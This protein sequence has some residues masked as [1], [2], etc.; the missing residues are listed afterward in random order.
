MDMCAWIDPR[1]IHFTHARISPH[2]SGCGRSVIDTLEEL[3]MGYI[4]PA[5]LPRIKVVPLV[6]Q[7][8]AEFLQQRKVN[9]R[10][11]AAAAANALTYY[12]SL[13]NRRLWVLKQCRE[14]GLLHENDHK[15]LVV[16]DLRKQMREKY[17]IDRCSLSA[18]FMTVKSATGTKTEDG[19]THK[20][21]GEDHRGPDDLPQSSS[22][23]IPLEGVGRA[24]GPSLCKGSSDVA[25]L[26]YAI[27][28]GVGLVSAMEERQIE[29]ANCATEGLLTQGTPALK[30]TW[31]G[32]SD[33]N[34]CSFSANG[35]SLLVGMSDGT[36][37]L[38]D[39]T[40]ATLIH[41]E[42]TVAEVTMCSFAPDGR[43]FFGASP[44]GAIQTWSSEGIQW[45][46][47]IGGG[48]GNSTQLHSCCYSP[49]GNVILGASSDGRLTF[50]RKHTAPIQEDDC[51]KRNKCLWQKEDTFDG[52]G[53]AAAYTCAFS[54]DG[55][56]VLS[57]S[58]DNTLRL[59]CIESKG[60]LKTLDGGHSGEI[61]CCEFSPCGTKILSGSED[62]T[63]VLWDIAS[64]KAE[65]TMNGHCE[66]VLTCCFSPDGKLIASGSVDNTLKLWD[67]SSGKL[68]ASLQHFSWVKTCKFSPDGKAVVSGG[69]D[70][71]LRWW[72]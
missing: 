47:D 48:A 70:T 11:A 27:G 26:A 1:I 53:G 18:K 58:K 15:I 34:A 44:G 46:E 3:K 35:K 22:A 55:K 65:I 21:D 16:L 62:S 43:T 50:W 52:V 31:E 63:L 57:G 24:T 28:L 49:C 61:T 39:A 2:F 19:A 45:S 42:S 51:V 17:T 40:N 71:L 32:P 60:L 14:L 9:K 8:D 68:R 37:R 64:E 33:I 10:A 56:T 41:T 13:N 4:T 66:L 23:G 72:G 30:L 12:F 20:T 29:G 6:P 59:W 36:L 7:D 25:S 69:V 67:A 54:P 38:L 5:D